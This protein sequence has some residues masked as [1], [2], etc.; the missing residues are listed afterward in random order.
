[1]AADGSIVADGATVAKGSVVN[2]GAAVAIGVDDGSDGERSELRPAVLQALRST[3][4]AIRPTMAPV[5]RMAVTVAPF[6]VCIFRRY[7]PI[8]T[9]TV[10]DVLARRPS[11]AGFLKTAR[12][13]VLVV[14]CTDLTYVPDVEP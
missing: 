8:A 14:S 12:N 6:G 13:S 5:A 10:C 7:G 4:A 11:S 9:V 3:P 1:M 2:V